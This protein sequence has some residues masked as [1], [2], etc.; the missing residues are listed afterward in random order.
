[1][2]RLNDPISEYPDP[3]YW[4]GTV[5]ITCM[6]SIREEHL[7]LIKST[8]KDWNPT[9]EWLE[10]D[11]GGWGVVRIVWSDLPCRKEEFLEPT[12]KCSYKDENYEANLE[13]VQYYVRCW[14]KP[15]ADLI[16]YDEDD[17]IEFILE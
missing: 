8:I 6:A 11:D 1:M 2:E 7:E 15:I 17:D 16:V 13:T 12:D 5:T 9:V 3:T 4:S 14:F 10:D